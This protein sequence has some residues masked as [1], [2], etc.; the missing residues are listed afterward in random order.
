MYKR[1]G[2]NLQSKC[3]GKILDLADSDWFTATRMNF[4][5]YKNANMKW[6]LVCRPDSCTCH[7]RLAF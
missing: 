1:T 4:A 7:A 3:D 5:A 6:R 2:M